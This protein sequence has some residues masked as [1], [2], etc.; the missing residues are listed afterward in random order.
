MIYLES[1]VFQYVENMVSLIKPRQTLFLAVDGVAPR[2][3]L[4]Q[5]RSRRFR[6]FRDLL[7]SQKKAFEAGEV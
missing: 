5:Q 3:K 2:A 4:N 7:Q 1:I 6:S